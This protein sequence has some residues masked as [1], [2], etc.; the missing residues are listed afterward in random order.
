MLKRETLIADRE[1]AGLALCQALSRDMDE[2]IAE[3][4]AAA[5]A[6]AGVALV[7]VGGYGRAE[8]SPRSDI[9]LVLIHDGRRDVRDVAE[10][11]WY[12]IWDQHLKLGHATRTV[13]EAV[14]LAGDDL[15][16]A[17][18]LI[19]AR[20][21]AGDVDLANELTGRAL[22]LWRK[23]AKRF[24]PELARTV[25]ERHATAGEV[26]FLLEP[27]LKQGRGGL[28]DV[29]AIRWA[30]AADVLLLD[31]DDERLEA[32]YLQLLAARVELHRISGKASDRLLLED[33]DAVAAS[34]GYGDADALMR[35]LSSA[36]RDI[37]W[38]SDEVWHR[39]SAWL[40]GPSMSKLRRDRELLPGVVLRDGD[41]H[42]HD[43][44]DPADDPLLVLRAAVAAARARTRVDRK[45]LERL[46]QRAAPL[47]VP[48]P[49]E[50]RA[51][52]SDLLLAGEPAV[53]II[54]ALDRKGLWVRLLPEWDPVRCKSQRNAY[55]TFTVDRH[56]C[57]A[58]ANAA[59]LADRVD[60]PDLLVVGT[61]LHDIGKG[62]SGDHA[63]VGIEVVGRIAA[64]MG[65][66]T[67]D[68]H[69][70][71]EMVR[72]HLL[73]P[74]I[75]TRRD[76]DDDGT[77]KRVANEVGSLSLLYLLHALTEADSL[78]TGP[79]AWNSWKAS[80]VHG[81]VERVA[82]VLGGGAVEEVTAETF[83]GPELL[84][85]MADG[86]QVIEGSGNQLLVITLDRPGL[87]SRVSGVLALHGF[88][89]LDANAF[90]SDDGMAVERFRVES[91]IGP[92]IPWDRVK[93]D[94]EL[95]LEGKLALTARLAER[96]R[97]YSSWTPRRVEAGDGRARVTFDNETSATATVVEVHAPDS[98]GLLYRVTRAIAELDLDIRT[99][100]IQTLGS[101]VVDAFYVRDRNGAKITDESYL[102]ELE[103]A[104][105]HALEAA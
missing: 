59:A 88:D 102:L 4:F 25:R 69:L 82:H 57:Q 9:D 35:S 13:K 97:R 72:L 20:W 104:L 23:K 39:I 36:A 62:Y 100:K 48:W 66:D 86:N 105:L 56:L 60:R 17:T 67:E 8:L 45:S 94:L 83:P 30:A 74:D 99:A 28:R 1:L 19:S 50:A 55:H 47:P 7:A 16:T 95:A 42:L 85:R 24:L 33:Q 10:R 46:A 64:R 96:A 52:F 68:T 84:Q 70:L 89:V 40:K 54:E 91:S 38:A 98:I 87:F 15:E 58:A 26:A 2:W 34:L 71:Q 27:D 32:A 101:E 80:L 90:T 21:V 11:I 43:T 93:R 51:L 65:Y 5:G 44:A 78:A 49:S 14:A 63:V 77:I 103:R 73:L 29:H 6:P 92:V 12:P 81:L 53:P 37:A 31:E 18:S 61:L 22:S 79:A 3:L 76:L 41:V 75:A